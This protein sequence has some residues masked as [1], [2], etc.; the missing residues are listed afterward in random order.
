MLVVALYGMQD[1]STCWPASRASL[2]DEIGHPP[3]VSLKVGEQQ[4]DGSLVFLALGRSVP[5]EHG[6]QDLQ[7][8]TV[9]W[10]VQPALVQE[11][12]HAPLP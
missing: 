9:A 8:V 12:H 10:A 2:Q 6:V 3:A 5:E 11:A 7:A 1:S 4:H